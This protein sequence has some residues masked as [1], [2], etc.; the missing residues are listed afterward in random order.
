MELSGD[1]LFGSAQGSRNVAFW[2]PTDGSGGLPPAPSA[3]GLA[4]PLRRRD[5][6]SAVA[7]NTSI[8]CIK[9]IRMC[10]DIYV[11]VHMCIYIYIFIHID[12]RVCTHICVCMCICTHM[13]M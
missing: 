5:A 8:S 4:L 12:I 11:S 1:Q 9:I 6:I 2:S 3:E 10:I 7:R 13:Y